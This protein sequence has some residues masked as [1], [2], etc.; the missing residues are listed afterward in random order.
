M[1]H[2]ASKWGK[3]QAEEIVEELVNQKSL[4]RSVETQ[5][6]N[7]VEEGDSVEALEVFL[8][9]RTRRNKTSQ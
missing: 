1:A 7:H 4:P 2:Q 8:K 5:M 9:C 3:R 6:L